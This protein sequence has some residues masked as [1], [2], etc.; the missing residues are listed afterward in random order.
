MLARLE[1]AYDA[2]HGATTVSRVPPPGVRQCEI[3]E[4]V[5]ATPDGGRV[6]PRPLS[7]LE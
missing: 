5:A 3:A 7:R 1:T 6:D 2:V 4:A